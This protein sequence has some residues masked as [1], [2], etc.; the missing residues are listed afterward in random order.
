MSD[1]E[2]DKD[3]FVKAFAAMQAELPVIVKNAENPH[4]HSR[5]ADLAA[6]V[7]VTRPIMAKH[8]FAVSQAPSF[9]PET[10]DPT[11]ITTFM[12]AASGHFLE[13]EML[14]CMAK[15]DP[16]GQGSGITYARRYAYS[17][18]LGLVTEDDADAEGVSGPSEAPQAPQR[19]PAPRLTHTNAEPPK[20]ESLDEEF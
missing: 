1:N 20:G 15:N 2:L 17:A 14:L 5:F 12:H 10:G 4:F 19:R 6:I 3:V 18:M 8:G 7:Q 11:L 16:Q 13:S 9:R